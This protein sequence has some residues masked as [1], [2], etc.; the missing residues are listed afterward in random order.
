MVM[1]NRT[2]GFTI[3]ELLIVIVVIAVLASLSYVGY[4]SISNRAY[5]SRVV[6]AVAE[7]EKALR[8]W[9]AETGI[10]KPLGNYGSTVPI[11]GLNCEDGL[12]SGFVGTESYVCTTEDILRHNGYLPESFTLKLPGNAYFLPSQ[13]GTRSIM[14]YDCAGIPGRYLLYWTLRQPS[15][16]DT[17]KL[18]SA[19]SSCGYSDPPAHQTVASW[20][21]RAAK[22]VQL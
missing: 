8:L 20:G 1:I 18:Y 3:V 14:L 21:M 15:A 6:S 10:T 2:N 11:S 12:G 5:D 4:T 19:M 17:E 13:G 9:S 7:F 22:I 16:S